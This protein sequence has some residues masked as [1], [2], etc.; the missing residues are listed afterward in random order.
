MDNAQQ[1]KNR[2]ADPWGLIQLFSIQLASALMIRALHAEPC[3]MLADASLL[4]RC[5]LFNELKSPGR[6]WEFWLLLVW[7][8]SSCLQGRT[9][10]KALRLPTSCGF[11]FHL[12]AETEEL[13]GALYGFDT[14][15]DETGGHGGVMDIP[16]MHY[17][18]NQFNLPSRVW[19]FAEAGTEDGEIWQRDWK[20][21]QRVRH[22][23]N[24]LCSESGRPILMD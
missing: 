8:D 14:P 16:L 9:E 18:T 10:T 1:C 15:P 11:F 17:D 6:N 2:S 19:G 3:W 22:P 24:R 5:S 7:P 13:H 23:M 12:L 20:E 4:P 21:A